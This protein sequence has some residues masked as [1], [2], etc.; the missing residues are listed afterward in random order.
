VWVVPW[1][2]PYGFITAEARLGLDQIISGEILKD[3]SE[4]EVW[5]KGKK[6]EIRKIKVKRK[7]KHRATC[8]T[9]V[10]KKGVKNE[11]TLSAVFNLFRLYETS[12]DLSWNPTCYAETW[13]NLIPIDLL[14]AQIIP[15]IIIY[16]FGSWT[17]AILSTS[18]IVLNI[19]QLFVVMF[20]EIKQRIELSILSNVS[21]FSLTN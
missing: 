7:W 9:Q 17:T 4:V 5:R 19:F 16:L 18:F 14:Q 10:S 11:W 1:S 8:C 6:I 21:L 3:L 15:F 13:C 20:S 2:L 12:L